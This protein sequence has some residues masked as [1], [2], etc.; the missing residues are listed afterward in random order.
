MNAVAINTN[1]SEPEVFRP[2]IRS[3]SGRRGHITKGQT[4][5][6]EKLSHQFCLPFLPQALN[7]P[8]HFGS[9]A[10]RV[11]EVGFG[12][13]ETTAHIAKAH[14]E[15]HYL[16]CEVYPAGVGSL[17]NRIEQ[18]A[19]TNIRIIQ[20]D[21]VQV[22]RNMITPA[23]L[24][25]VHVFFPDP[26]RKKR[27]H[28]R[29]LISPPFLDLVARCLKPGGIIH[30][31][32][33]WQDYALQMHQTL[34]IHPHFKVADGHQDP[35]RDYGFCVRPDARPLTKFEARGL[36]LGHQVWDFVFKRQTNSP[37]PS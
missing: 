1:P 8:L 13:G 33:D 14:P 18:L 25:A 9:S 11:L 7:W 20:H 21:A 27:H 32:T 15:T 16:G 12:M 37:S 2:G 23:S 6:L 26:W 3:F 4:L 22:L 30:C 34:V 35:A 10:N 5:A 29:R 31:A 19:L 24:D 17:L 36:R 28:K